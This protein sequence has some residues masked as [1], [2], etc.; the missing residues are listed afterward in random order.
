LGKTTSLLGR[1]SDSDD[2]ANVSQ[3]L[4]KKEEFFKL[5]LKNRDT[6]GNWTNMYDSIVLGKTYITNCKTCPKENYVLDSQII[7]KTFEQQLPLSYYY[8]DTSQ[9][10]DKDNLFSVEVE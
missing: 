3:D 2:S 6:N 5:T 9:T 4:A 7:V 1:P 10:I 8:V